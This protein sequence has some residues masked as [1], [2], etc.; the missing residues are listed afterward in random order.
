M[1]DITPPPPSTTTQLANKWT[2]SP[3]FSDALLIAMR[4]RSHSGGPLPRLPSMLQLPSP[5]TP[6]TRSSLPSP[7]KPDSAERLKMKTRVAIRD[8]DPHRFQIVPLSDAD[9]YSFEQKR[10]RERQPLERAAARGSTLSRASLHSGTKNHLS[11]NT[12]APPKQVHDGPVK[13]DTPARST[14]LSERNKNVPAQALSSS[15][16]PASLRSKDASRSEGHIDNRPLLGSTK[17]PKQRSSPSETTKYN[18][19]PLHFKSPSLGNLRT[20][21][22]LDIDLETTPLPRVTSCRK[23]T[24]TLSVEHSRGSERIAAPEPIQRPD[25]RILAKDSLKR[26]AIYT[27]S[28]YVPVHDRPNLPYNDTSSNL[29]KEPLASYPF[30]SSIPTS[31]NTDASLQF[32]TQIGSAL[33]FLDMPAG[34]LVSSLKTQ[35]SISSDYS[36]NEFVRPLSYRDSPSNFDLRQAATILEEHPPI[37]LKLLAEVDKAMEEW[38]MK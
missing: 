25:R 23:R 14:I 27:Q 29:S 38:S 1:G 33:G 9:N 10:S 12:A 16:T 4:E 17:Q 7:T 28:L 24:N 26:H 18:H 35:S 22:N 13:F 11:E 5:E 32:S 19:N 20:K 21:P 2:V 15:D 8:R 37:I 3:E 30:R 31:H 34:A 36:E 6:G